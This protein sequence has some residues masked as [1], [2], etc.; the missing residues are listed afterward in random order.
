MHLSL[1]ENQG[2]FLGDGVVLS[3]FL[4]K[5]LLPSVSH[6]HKSGGSEG[7]AHTGTRWSAGGPAGALV[8]RMRQSAPGLQRPCVLTSVRCRQ[9]SQLVI[10]LGMR[11]CCGFSVHFPGVRQC[12][13]PFMRWLAV[14][15]MYIYKCLH[16]FSTFLVGFYILLWLICS[17]CIYWIWIFLFL[18]LGHIYMLKI[19]FPC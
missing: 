18:F 17:S 13:L 16:L 11:R 5:F 2:H 14:V 7:Q 15:F 8:R 1:S 4:W 9:P 12:R 3:F 6:T 10:L 19:V